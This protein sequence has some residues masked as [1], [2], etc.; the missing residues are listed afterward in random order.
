MSSNIEFYGRSLDL[1]CNI[2]ETE[3]ERIMA[4]IS[5]LSMDTVKELYQLCI[6][7]EKYETCAI[8]LKI[9]NKHKNENTK[10]KSI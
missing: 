7:Y 10:E 2:I 4:A 5:P 3:E 9:I 8:L 6:L 1:I